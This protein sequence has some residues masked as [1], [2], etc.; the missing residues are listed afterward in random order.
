MRIAISGSSGLIGR[1]LWSYLTDLGHSLVRIDRKGNFRGKVDWIIDLAA[2]GNYH[3][4]TD[5][6]EIYK[7][8]VLRLIRI[9]EKAKGVKAVILTSSSSVALPI[10]TFYAASKLAVESLGKAY[11]DL[12]L[13]VVITRPATIIG[14]GEVEHHLIPALIN[15]CF[16]SEE[17]DFVGSPTHDFLSADDFVKAVVLLAKNAKKLKGKV[18]NVGSGK[19]YSNNEVRKMV[20]SS[21]GNP[22]KLR[23]K[24]QLRKYDSTHW[25]VKP[26]KELKALG[27]KPKD[28]IMSTIDRMVDQ[29]FTDR[30]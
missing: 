23:I 7:V 30:F 10:T 20:E 17:M 27:W 19:S 13:P 5:K 24:T 22:A 4:Q 9:L 8:N 12:G 2:Y 14:V 1:H 28:S 29:A 11:A 26:S 16:T 3:F 6:E 15:S 18:I 21:V 25:V